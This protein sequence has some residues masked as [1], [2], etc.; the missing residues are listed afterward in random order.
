[1]ERLP[2][3]VDI[4]I[5]TF[6][7]LINQFIDFV[8]RIIG[9]AFIILVGFGVAKALALVVAKVLERV[10]LNKIGDRLTEIDFI[11]RLKTEIKLSDIVAK[12]VYYFVLLVFLMAATETLGVS[13]ITDMVKSLVAF[14]PRLIAAAIMLQVGVLIADALKGAV[15]SLCQSFNIASGRLLGMIVFFFF[16]VITLI[17]ALGQA[18]I[19]TE[20]LESS[21]NLLIGGVIFAFAVGYGMA[22]RDVMANILSSFYSKN[23]FREGQT[24]RVDTVK[25][26][27]TRIDNTALTLQTDDTI[28]VIPLQRLQSHTVELFD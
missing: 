12:V 10:G 25:G 1:M 18:G 27:I 9:A 28:T 7:T 17:S 15:I 5:N 19:N 22:S 3:F 26:I 14:I 16:L 8:P 2:A 13:A 11:R 20:L 24:I 4:L 21:F 23:R 6:T